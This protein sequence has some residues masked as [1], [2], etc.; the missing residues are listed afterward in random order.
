L[1]VKVKLGDI[2]KDDSFYSL[3]YY[4][5]KG[6]SG[7]DIAIIENVTINPGEVVLVSTGISVEI[8][9]GY[10]I[11]VRLRSSYALKGLII[12]NSPGTIDSDYRGE[13]KLILANIGKEK[14]KLEKYD[15]VAQLV[16][17]KVERIEWEQVEHLFPTERGE[18]GFGSTGGAE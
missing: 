17:S 16:L 5:T 18:G 3:P 6:S 13:I 14:I 10:E 11:Q 4:A 2:I 9:V 12:A 1:K 8:P 15:K 7:A